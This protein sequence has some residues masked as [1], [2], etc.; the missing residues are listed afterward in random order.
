[1]DALAG[2]SHCSISTPVN[3]AASTVKNSAFWVALH[4]FPHAVQFAPNELGLDFKVSVFADN[5]PLFLNFPET[6]AKKRE[7]IQKRAQ[8]PDI[9][10]QLPVPH[11]PT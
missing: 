5:W 1:L 9:P 11:H 8:I 7:V 3:V 4:E 6:S 2:E 10:G